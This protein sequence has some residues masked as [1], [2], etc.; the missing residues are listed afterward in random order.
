[1]SFVGWLDHSEDEQTRMR[2]LLG[3]FESRGTVDDLGLGTIRDTISNRLFPGTSV[4]QT[5]ARYYLFVP[6]IFMRAEQ[7]HRSK[8]LDKAEDMERH[9]VLALQRGPETRGVIGSRAGKDVRT[10]PSAIYW[11]GLATYRIFLKRGLTRSQYDRAVRRERPRAE[12]E[13]E[14][15]ERS[16]ALWQRSIPNPPEGFFDFDVA[17]FELSSGEAKWLCERVLSTEIEGEQNLLCDYVRLLLAGESVPADAFWSEPLPERSSEGTGELVRH[18]LLFSYANEVAATLYNIM[19]HEQRADHTKADLATAEELR[20]ALDDWAES[21]KASEL[22]EWCSDLSGFWLLMSQRTRVPMLT[23]SFVDGW[24][25]LVS[26]TEVEDLA[27]NPAA[28][29]LI[30]TREIQHKKGLARFHNDN[31]LAEWNGSAGLDPLE[32][33][34]TQ[35]HRLLTDL[36]EGLNGRSKIAS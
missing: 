22:G 11:S 26:T 20:S 14:L 17:D 36:D 31:R 4:I 8:V 24:A 9:L 16:D 5:R 13:D 32:Y 21:P 15:A 6:W 30:R 34:W 12:V 35:V 33:R 29:D 28:R 19:L 10:L 23:K 18:A 2:E 3:M 7:R 25:S 27:D 1:M